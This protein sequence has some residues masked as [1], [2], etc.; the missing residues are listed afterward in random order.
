MKPTKWAIFVALTIVSSFCMK[1]VGSAKSGRFAFVS[2][3]HAL[4]VA[5][6]SY[7]RKIMYHPSRSR[8]LG[9]LLL[10]ASN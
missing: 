5:G 6:I 7:Q 2:L 4:R 10:I 9:L 1:R 3:S 8:I